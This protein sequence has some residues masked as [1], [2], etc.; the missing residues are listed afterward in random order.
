MQDLES[1]IIS[2]VVIGY[3]IG[4]TC[5]KKGFGGRIRRK[6]SIQKTGM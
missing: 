6:K 2:C 3:G 4:G 5:N 1:C